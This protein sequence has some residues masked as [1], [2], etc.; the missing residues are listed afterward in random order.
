[1]RFIFQQRPHLRSNV[2]KEFM[3]Y[4][5]ILS[6][7]YWQKFVLSPRVSHYQTAILNN[8]SNVPPHDIYRMVESLAACSVQETQIAMPEGVDVY[9]VDRPRMLKFIETE[10]DKCKMTE[11]LLVGLDAEWSPYYA[12]SRSA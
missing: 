2:V 11:M 9:V 12:S 4:K 10:I 3:R 6:S 5:D 1:M 8:K 7:E